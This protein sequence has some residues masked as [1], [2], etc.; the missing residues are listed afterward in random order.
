MNTI[1]VRR[2]DTVQLE[3][4][5]TNN[6]EPFVPES[7]KVVFSVGGVGGCLFSLEAENMVVKIP[8]EQTKKLRPGDYKFDVRVY[9]VGKNL[10]ATPIFGTFRVLEVVNNDLV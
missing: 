2:G 4:T 5:L 10:V 8:H 3:L 1:D 7:E 9:D 6:G